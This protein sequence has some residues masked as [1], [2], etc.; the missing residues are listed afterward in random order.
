MRGVPALVAVILPLRP[1]AR[2]ARDDRTGQLA[3]RGTCPVRYGGCGVTAGGQRPAAVRPRARGNSQAAPPPTATLPATPRRPCAML[4]G[5]RESC[6]RQRSIHEQATD[7]PRPEQ[8]RHSATGQPGRPSAMIKP[9]SL[10]IDHSARHGRQA[11]QPELPTRSAG[12]IREAPTRALLAWFRG[13]LGVVSGPGTRPDPRSGR[14]RQGCPVTGM[15]AG[16]QSWHLPAL[17]V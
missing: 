15:S 14:R 11:N 16:S 17:P 5:S 13:G 8:E 2:L 12:M 4:P 10:R 9:L 6:H 1:L 3:R 7:Q